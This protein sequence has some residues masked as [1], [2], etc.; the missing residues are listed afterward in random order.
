MNP[1]NKEIA[2]STANQT[3]GMMTHL[4]VARKV[5]PRGSQG[6]GRSQSPHVPLGAQPPLLDEIHGLRDDQAE[7]GFR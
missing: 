4:D 2:R 6:G 1:E 3:P 5:E 7:P